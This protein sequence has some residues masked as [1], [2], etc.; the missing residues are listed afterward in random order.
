MTDGDSAKLARQTTVAAAALV[1]GIALVGGRRVGARPRLEPIEV[2]QQTTYIITPT[3]ADGWVDYPE[4]V[5]WMRRASLDAGGANA[6]VDAGARAGTRRAADR[7]R[8]RPRCSSGWASMSRAR[9]RRRC[10]RSRTSSPWPDGPPRN[11]R[12]PRS[13][14]CRR[15]ARPT[16]RAQ[17]RSRTIIGLAHRGGCGGHGPADGSAGG[18]PLR[19]G[20]ARCGRHGKLRS[21]QSDPPRR[22]RGR[23][24]VPRGDEVA[25]RPRAGQLERRRGALAAR[26]A[27]RALRDRRRIRGRGGVLEGGADR[28]RRSGRQPGDQPGAAVDD[29]GRPRRQARLSAR[30]RDV[31]VSSP[32]GAGGERNAAGARARAASR[33][34]PA[35]RRPAG[36]HRHRREAGSDQPGVR[37]DRRRAANARSRAADRPRRTGRAHDGGAGRRCRPRAC[38]A[39]RSRP[40]RT[41]GSR[42]SRSRWPGGSA[43]VA[44]C[45]RRWPS[46]PAR[47]RIPAAVAPS[48]TRSTAAAYRLYGVGG[49][50]RDDH[51]APEHDVVVDAREPPPPFAAP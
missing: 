2:S 8:S 22:R 18:E 17:P 48:S 16:R 42:C 49:D 43:T 13:N 9:T 29:A 31:D 50:G 5:D 35:G 38:S 33:E 4:A 34:R 21:R 12:P 40:S 44:S 15:A 32:R 3:R 37:R 19:A 36:A 30:D 26:A 45:P 27:R 20:A 47:P 11:R 25:R 41:T 14:G 1:V 23:A 24:G 51:G 39:S 6:A 46:W 7:R 28:H 10:R